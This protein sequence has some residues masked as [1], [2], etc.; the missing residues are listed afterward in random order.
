MVIKTE[1]ESNLERMLLEGATESTMQKDVGIEEEQSSSSVEKEAA[2]L[3]GKGQEPHSPQQEARKQSTSEQEA[4]GSCGSSES[5]CGSGKR[6]RESA[7]LSSNNTS[8]VIEA[9]IPNSRSMPQ[10][11]KVE[12][13][14]NPILKPTPAKSAGIAC[15]KRLPRMDEEK[16]A[17][18]LDL[19]NPHNLLLNYLREDGYK[20]YTRKSTTLSDFFIEITNE[21]IEAYSTE[22]VKATRDRDISLLRAMHKEGKMLQCS[23]RFGESLLHMACRRGYTDVVRFLIKEAD[24]SLRVKDDFGRTPLHDACWSA[25]PNF[26]LME[27]IIE[28]DPDLLLIEDVRG[29]SPFSYARRSHWKEW[30]EFLTARRETLRLNTFAE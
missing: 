10:L 13:I 8:K 6:R 20:A 15:F 24:V 14:E 21:H 7:Y 5:D 28:H 3:D 2:L 26:D 18:E 1:E 9:L 16:K 4:G 25:D 12:Q 27:L 17:E 29:H 19:S 30:S 23:N 11:N 22:I